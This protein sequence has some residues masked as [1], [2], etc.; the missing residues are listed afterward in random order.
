MADESITVVSLDEEHNDKRSN[1]YRSTADP[2]ALA[3]GEDMPHKIIKESALENQRKNYFE[4]TKTFQ[5]TV[6]RVNGDRSTVKRRAVF[7]GTGE[8]ERD[9]ISVQA[10]IPVLHKMIPKP[11]MIPPSSEDAIKNKGI[12]EMHPT[13]VARSEG[14]L[15]TI[16]EGDVILV[17]FNKGPG[18]GMQ[19]DG[20]ILK[21]YQKATIRGD[22]ENGEDS[23]QLARVFVS[24]TENATMG[25]ILSSERTRLNAPGQA[26]EEP[27]SI[28]TW[29]QLGTIVEKGG[30]EKIL[31][32]L[33]SKESLNNFN[34]VNRGRGGDSPGDARDYII[35]N[36]QN[37]TE[38]NISKVIELQKGG[39]YTQN[40]DMTPVRATGVTPSE[41]PGFL[42]VGAYQMIPETL[43]RIKNRAGCPTNTIF[44]E[45]TQK[46][47]CA[48]LLLSDNKNLGNYLLSKYDNSERAAQ[49]VAYIWASIP[50]Q[51]YYEETGCNRGDSAYC[52]DSAGNRASSSTSPEEVISIIQ[53]AR[54]DMQPLLEELGIS[55][56][57]E[58]AA[59]E[60]TETAE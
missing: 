1:P 43:K 3:S 13:F 54:Q 5:A 38:M 59:S 48:D 26:S 40:V 42:A 34:A 60:P 4:D 39:S 10:R 27:A 35:E 25:E 37:L 46:R 14:E 21:I 6:L 50:L 11:K 32:Y 17:Q 31:N 36:P 53:S 23:E 49:V 28:F 22:S 7:S 47:L 55:R 20:H 44:N 58:E 57:T 30:L 56:E 33:S 52:R 29:D 16:G 18:H 2:L 24:D 45:N 12:I 8:N 41:R 51:Y 15:S 9:F 19:I